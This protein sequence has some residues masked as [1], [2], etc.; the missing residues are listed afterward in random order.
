MS[1]LRPGD[2]IFFHGM[3]GATRGVCLVVE[4]RPGYTVDL[5]LYKPVV[6]VLTQHRR[7]YSFESVDL[8][9]LFW[10]RISER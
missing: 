6:T 10:D 3:V 2:A 9:G 8:E 1:A 4:V 5:I 7:L